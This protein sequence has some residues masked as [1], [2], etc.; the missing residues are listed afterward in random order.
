M[1]R[2]AA[3]KN[4]AKLEQTLVKIGSLPLAHKLRRGGKT[5]SWYHGPLVPAEGISTSLSRTLN[6]PVRHADE[7][8]LYDA[9]TAMLDVSYSAAWELGR[10]LTIGNTSLA[11][12]LQE[13]KLAHAHKLAQ[14]E[15]KIVF[16]HLQPFL[17]S[18]YASTTS[19][20]TSQ[21]LQDYFEGLNLL[22]GVP[23]HYLVPD[24]SYLPNES[25]R[26]FQVD[27][28]WIE[29]LLD[30]AFSPGRTTQLDLKR[31]Q[32]HWRPPS[33]T[34]HP[35]LSGI[36]LRSELVAGW[37]ALQVDGFDERVTS[38]AFIAEKRELDSI[39]GEEADDSKAKLQRNQISAKIKE[40]INKSAS[41]SDDLTLSPEGP[42]SWQ[43]VDNKRHEYYR[44]EVEADG[45]LKIYDEDQMPT[46]R[47]E[48]LSP[49]VLLCLFKGIVKTLDIHL[50]AESLHFG[51]IKEDNRVFKE[52]KGLIDGK[53]IIENDKNIIQEIVWRDI[54]LLTVDMANTATQIGQ[55]PKVKAT[56]T[57]EFG[58]SH[59]AVEMIEGVPKMRYTLGVRDSR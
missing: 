50:P 54:A 2:T 42:G 15:E 30:G 40:L 16:S 6:L 46:L 37:P 31:E 41:L 13:W 38:K 11:L 25:I 10:L 53:E 28:Y 26:F 43:I 27:P 17:E 55:H 32:Q 23:F 24:E 22:K 21:T 36:L 56:F 57:G 14:D 45:G 34:A 20:S 7:L 58:S 9:E 18:E 8:L 51:F 3:D 59:L 4:N 29:A 49:N 5:V 35:V 12:K 1:L 19:S 47:M 39:T 52:L 33:E 44:V 48:R